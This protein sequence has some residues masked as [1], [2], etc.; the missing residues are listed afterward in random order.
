MNDIH[1]PALQPLLPRPWSPSDSDNTAKSTVSLEEARDEVHISRSVENDVVP[2]T[3]I[4]GRHLGWGSAYILIISRVIGSGI[5]A[6]PGNIVK[7]VGSVA[8]ALLLWVVGALISWFGLA[9]SLEYGCM[10]PRSGGEK[11]YLEFTYRHPRFLTSTLVA[12]QA[13]LLGFTA[14]NCIV[15]SEYV[16]FA[17]NVEPTPVAQKSLAVGL[18]TLITVIHGCFLKTGLLIQNVLGW[19]KVSLVIFMVFTG[20][21]VVI[22]RGRP[23]YNPSMQLVTWESLWNG[24]N[25]NWE[26]LS[27]A[28]FKVFYSYAGLGNVNNVLNEVKDPIRTL[29]S[30]APAGLLTACALYLLINV[31]YFLV[32]PLEEI[33]HTGELIAALFFERTFGP[34]V[35]RVV[36][37]GAVAISAAGNVMVVTFA[38]ARLNQEI[39]RQGFLPF[40]RLISSS[41]PF[42]APLGGLIVHYIPSLLVITLPP[43]GDVYSFILEIEGYAGQFFALAMSIGLVWLRHKRPDIHRPYKA[44]LPAVGIR[45]AL[46]LAL[47]AAPFFPPANPGGH[48]RLFNS[49]YA[50]VG[51]AIILFG[52]IYWYI[53]TVLLPRYRGY[54]LEEK[55]EM[56]PE[57]FERPFQPLNV[58]ITD[59][60]G[61][62]SKYTLDSH[63]FQI[64]RHASKE[65]DFLDDEK[66]KA[67]YYP[68]TEQLLKDATGASR[69][70]IF[71][72]TIRRQTSD[73]RTEQTQLR[74]PVRRV[75]IDQSYNASRNRVSYHLPEEADNLLQRRFQIV[76]V[77]RPIKTIYKDPLAIA[78]AYSVPDSDLVGAAL[79]YPNRK[80]ETY[81]VKA[82]PQHRWYFKYAQRS[83]EVTLIKCFDSLEDGRA[84]R[85]PHTA[86]VDSSEE[87]KEPR[88]SI[89]VRALVFYDE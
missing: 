17:L 22:L 68:E 18:L 83:D 19:V 79:I 66:I 7:S 2:E 40:S 8:L 65:K 23:N 30:V 4:L 85:V 28:L 10:L 49:M 67:E 78:D 45:I 56:K 46:S 39:A 59:V 73:V 55:V 80:G 5:F 74:G 63:G 25:W 89:E 77:W 29:K 9:V 72:H 84:R 16:L 64:Y 21:S 58:T 60:S 62:E 61:N 87:D 82:N 47:I 32:V 35:G 37:P 31:A 3:A 24:S 12:V 88:E 54:T 70:F 1:D 20:L 44:W 51:I 48:T 6:T 14:S 57:T 41:R 15:F 13:V 71:D 38:L 53:W 42:N 69:I 33:K 81:A 11:V 27:T 76:N 34:T 86:F 75:H 43:S 26:I 50:V 36:L 52:I